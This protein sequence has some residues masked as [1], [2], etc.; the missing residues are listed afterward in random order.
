MKIRFLIIP[1]LF[2]TIANA[3]DDP[4]VDKQN[5]T[6]GETVW[7]EEKIS[8]TTTWIENLVKPLTVWMEQQVNG[9]KPEDNNQEV[10]QENS[11]HSEQEKAQSATQTD[12]EKT[13]SPDSVIGSEQAGVLAKEHIAGDVLYIKLMSK[14]QQYRVKLISKLGEIHIIYINAISGEI[15]SPTTAPLGSAGSK[16][17]DDTKERP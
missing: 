2:S 12:P 16:P 15:V 1:L 7:I 10:T 3:D 17:S 14:T 13:L 5:T 8:P 11:P 6:K 4:N 9:P